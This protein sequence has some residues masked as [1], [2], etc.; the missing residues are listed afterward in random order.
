MV[1]ILVIIKRV[2]FYTLFYTDII[3]CILQINNKHQLIF[4]FPVCVYLIYTQWWK[5]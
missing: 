4:S 5:Y 3:I 1:H 2:I